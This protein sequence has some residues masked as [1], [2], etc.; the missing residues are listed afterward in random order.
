MADP[1]FNPEANAQDSRRWE[2]GWNR[3]FP[4]HTCGFSKKS[5]LYPSYLRLSC[6]SAVEKI[7]IEMPCNTLPSFRGV[8][9]QRDVA[10]I[11]F[12]RCQP[13]AIKLQAGVHEIPTIRIFR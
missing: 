12:G 13:T 3:D 5:P 4:L 1:I 9:F 2:K 6:P 8:A 11:D 10:A 7:Q